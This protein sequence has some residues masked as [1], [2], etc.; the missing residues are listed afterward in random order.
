MATDVNQ[1][2]ADAAE[3]VS[4]LSGKADTMAQ[5]AMSATS[6]AFGVAP[7]QAFAPGVSGPGYQGNVN[8]SHD[9]LGTYTNA[10]RDL[11]PE[12]ANAV[13]EY[14]AQWFPACVFAHTEDWICTTILTGGTGLPPGIEEAIW[15]RARRREA[16]EAKRLE[17]EALTQGA[18]RGFMIPPGAVTYRMLQVQ[19]DSVDRASNINRDEAIKHIDIIIEN[20]RFAVDQ[21]VKVR[22]QVMSALGDFI[23]AHFLPEELALQKANG[24][25]QAKQVLVNSAA[26]YYRAQVAAASLQVEAQAITGRSYDA[27]NAAAAQF[28]IAMAQT[29]SSAATTIAATYG[30]AAAGAASGILGVGQDQIIRVGALA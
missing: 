12:Y 6:G 25:L 29:R 7:Y 15:E 5:A 13:A 8:L 19:Q 26:D 18:A 1:I 2:I 17:Q 4:A 14:I 9:F 10:L 30:Q 16:R 21:G 24:V 27:A 22:G 3:R 23:R 11:R 28:A 20:V